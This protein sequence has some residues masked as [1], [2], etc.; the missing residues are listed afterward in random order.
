MSVLVTYTVKDLLIISEQLMNTLYKTPWQAELYTTNDDYLFAQ[1]KKMHLKIM[2]DSEIKHY[3]S[4]SS[5]LFDISNRL[6][7][8]ENTLTGTAEAVGSV[9]T[10]RTCIF[11]TKKLITALNSTDS[12]FCIVC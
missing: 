8:I 9:A 1:I 5:T 11:R 3:P 6:F 7:C 2:E 12:R 10:V 4:G